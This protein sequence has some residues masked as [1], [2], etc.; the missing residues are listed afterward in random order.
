MRSLCRVR[1]GDMLNIFR[2]NVRCSQLALQALGLLLN[3]RDARWVIAEDFSPFHLVEDGVVGRVYFIASVYIRGEQP[4]LDSFGEDFDLMGRSV[5][6]KHRLPIDVVGVCLCSARM[7]R[8]EGE[9]VKV[10]VGG[11]DGRE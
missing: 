2:D 1:L 5:C 6:A 11:N 7:V 9:G 3:L 8:R 4:A 10:L